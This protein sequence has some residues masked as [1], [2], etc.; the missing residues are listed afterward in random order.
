[1]VALDCAGSGWWVE[2]SDGAATLSGAEQAVRR[3]AAVRRKADGRRRS[4]STCSG[5]GSSG[6][7]AVAKRAP[8]LLDDIDLDAGL[9]FIVGVQLRQ[10]V[11]RVPLGPEDIKLLHS[12]G[13]RLG[14]CRF[15]RGRFSGR[16]LCG[17]RL[18]GCRLCRRRSG[19][20]LRGTAGKHS[21]DQ[22]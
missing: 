7:A 6:L 1:M 20:R 9:R 11:G 3:R 21:N 22:E 15:S 8:G 18:C 12:A 14:G 2:V 16:W 17:C 19:G 5:M 13:G 4:M 10:E